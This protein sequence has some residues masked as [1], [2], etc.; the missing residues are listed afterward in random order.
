MKRLGLIALSVTLLL[1]VGAGSASASR[2]GHD[3]GHRRHEQRYDNSRYQQDE[4][5]GR[6]YRYDR[7][8][9]D[10]GYNDYQGR[11]D[12]GGYEYRR[13]GNGSQG[14]CQSGGCGNRSR[15]CDRSSG[16]CRS[17][18]SPGP[19]KDSPVTICLPYSC[20]SGGQQSGGNRQNPPPD[21][22]PASDQPQ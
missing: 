19:F 17:S 21:Q 1:T 12:E 8:E 4:Y 10:G 3:R 22:P 5:S 11:D 7:G 14:D 6:Q 15:R 13:G 2:R 16:D 20:N 9:Y 18:F